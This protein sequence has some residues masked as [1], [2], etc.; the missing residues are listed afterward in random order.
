M[1]VE[2]FQV[3][4]DGAFPKSFYTLKGAKSLPGVCTIV[5]KTVAAPDE[6]SMIHKAKAYLI[7]NKLKNL[8]KKVCYRCQYDCPSQI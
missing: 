1:R 5:K 2:I 4:H 3:I 7:H 8:L 6:N